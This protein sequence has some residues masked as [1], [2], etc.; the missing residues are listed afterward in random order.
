MANPSVFFVFFPF[1]APLS[2]VFSAPLFRPL[3]N[4]SSIDS[5]LLLSDPTLLQRLAWQQQQLR[6]TS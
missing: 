2:H 5:F 4:I 6:H 1:H 3:C